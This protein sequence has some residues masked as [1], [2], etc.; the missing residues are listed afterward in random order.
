MKDT[1]KHDQMYL[2]GCVLFFLLLQSVKPNGNARSHISGNHDD[3][4]D[5][6]VM[7]ELIR[8]FTGD[9]YSISAKDTSQYKEGKTEG[10]VNLPFKDCVKISVFQKLVDNNYSLALDRM[11]AFIDKHFDRQTSE[12]FVGAVLEVI[13]KDDSI[14]D[15]QKF[16]VMENGEAL[17]K[18]QLLK[19]KSFELEPF[20]VGILLFV[21]TQRCG[22]N[23]KGVATLNI[24]G[25]KENRKPRVF[26]SDIGQ[27]MAKEITVS[28]WV[29]DESLN[30]VQNKKASSDESEKADIIEPQKCDE[31]SNAEK[32][33]TV[34]NH[35]TNVVQNGDHNINVTNNGTINMNL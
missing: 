29:K 13:Q 1:N 15:S 5:P 9:N 27:M 2:C 31:R 21:L 11:K 28:D 24:L 4:S 22:E 14:R 32:N 20:L 35:Q 33:Q 17:T 16:Y 30:G 19:N 6:I 8:T 7:N 26:S 23:K 12:W 25:R 34:I 3:H 10:T 18:G